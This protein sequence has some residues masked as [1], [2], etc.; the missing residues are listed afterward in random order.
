MTSEQVA[1]SMYAGLSARDR[2]AVDAWR[3]LGNDLVTAL[4]NSDVLRSAA[5]AR[6][7]ADD[8]ADWSRR[9]LGTDRDLLR[10]EAAE[11]ESAHA[12][13]ARA[14]GVHVAEVSIDDDGSGRTVFEETSRE[15]AAIIACA[16]HVWVGEFRG[17]VFPAGPRGCS[18]DG[19]ALA[20]STNADSY[21]VDQ[22]VRRARL[23]L[24]ECRDDVLQLARVLVADGRA[25]F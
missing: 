7:P 12:V 1:W 11:H 16:G 3:T 13:V 9:I 10:Q 18:G 19:Q 20:R 2:A 25:T 14:L 4:L 6:F 23:I 21:N 15:A 22:A 8:V 17:T 24:T 5:P